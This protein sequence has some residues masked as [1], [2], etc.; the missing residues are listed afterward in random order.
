MCTGCDL[1][2]IFMVSF[3]CPSLRLLNA[4]YTS[5]YSRNRILLSAAFFTE[6][7]YTRREMSNYMYIK[8]LDVII[9]PC[10][11]RKGALAMCCI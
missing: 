1:D 4:T 7:S 5:S 11:N 8:L 2:E 10:S 3:V 9:D 6:I